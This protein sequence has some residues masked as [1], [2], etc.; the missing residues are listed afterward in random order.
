MIKV[1]ATNWTISLML[2]VLRPHYHLI[3]YY[4]IS[5][6][7]VAFN[8]I[9]CSLI[10]KLCLRIYACMY[11]CMNICMYVC[12]YICMYICIFMYACLYECMYVNMHLCMYVCIYIWMYGSIN[13]SINF[14]YIYIRILLLLVAHDFKLKYSYKFIHDYCKMFFS[15]LH[16]I[17]QCLPLHPIRSRQ[18]RPNLVGYLCYST[19]IWFVL[20]T[21]CWI[22]WMEIVIIL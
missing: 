13:W 5:Y 9:S 18:Q 19:S 2:N 17:I 4:C 12:M 14:L 21:T 1:T 16:K 3:K 8:L 15:H 22:E 10:F 11:I 20:F 6:H 7:F